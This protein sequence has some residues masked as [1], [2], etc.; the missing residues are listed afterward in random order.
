MSCTKESLAQV[1]ARYGGVKA[2]SHQ[3][4][5]ECCI[6]EAVSVCE[7]RDWTSDPIQLD[8]PEVRPLNDAPWPDDVVRTE[9]ML[10]LA[11]LLEAWPGWGN[12]KRVAWVKAVALRTVREVLSITLRAANIN[13]RL[14]V[15]CEKA[16]DLVTATRASYTAAFSKHATAAAAATTTA[17]A[18]LAALRASHAH[19]ETPLR[20]AR[21]II[22]A[23]INA[24][25]AAVWCARITPSLPTLTQ[26]VTIWAEE[27]EKVSNSGS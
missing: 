22:D 6:L 2:G 26:A 9:Q 19:H 18:A 24:S 11:P 3:H 4:R 21:L 17:H 7:G 23:V 16:E 12:E 1:V 14:V 5:R 10:R 15:A 27:A 8:R 25:Q 13:E 20:L